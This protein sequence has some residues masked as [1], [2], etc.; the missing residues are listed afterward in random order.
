MSYQVIREFVYA[1]AAVHPA[2]G[3]LI[4]LVMPWVDTTTMSIFLRHL[5]ASI[6]NEHLIVL[7]DGAGWHHAHELAVP[8]T[9]S[10]VFLPPYSPQLNPTEHIWDHLRE[11]N[12]ANKTFDDLTAVEDTLCDGLNDLVQS[13]S[14]VRSLTDFEWLKT[15]SLM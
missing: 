2:S 13:P 15:L 8:A 14:V 3:T 9:L 7:L 12:F 1:L 10:L 4:A 6:P 5:A 11:N